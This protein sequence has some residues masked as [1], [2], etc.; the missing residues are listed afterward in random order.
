M[1]ANGNG[2]LPAHQKVRALALEE[3][4]TRVGEL[5]EKNAALRKMSDH[6]GRAMEA[7]ANAITGYALDMAKL[8]QRLDA[9]ERSYWRRLVLWV[10]V[11][12]KRISAACDLWLR[13]Q[14]RGGVTM[15]RI[16]DDEGE[17]MAHELPPAE[18]MD[19]ALLKPAANGCACCQCRG[20]RCMNPHPSHW[21]GQADYPGQSDY[22]GVARPALMAVE[23]SECVCAEFATG[24]ARSRR[25]ASRRVV[26]IRR[27]R[28]IP[29]PVE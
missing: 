17:S 3:A 20:I 5:E 29:V 4:L 19:R 1:G 28:S 27:G 25:A 6:Q 16:P 26:C 12:L 8:R 2:N 13:S 15:R 24:M 21:H 7:L 10:G 11:T 23:I 9:L 22:R 14:S 18:L